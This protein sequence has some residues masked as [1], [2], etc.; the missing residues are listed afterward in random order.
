MDYRSLA[1]RKYHPLITITWLDRVAV[2]SDGAPGPGGH[3]STMP[4]RVKLE[5][6]VREVRAG[7][8]ATAVW[9]TERRMSSRRS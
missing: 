8:R 3:R 1:L 2:E 5:S 4:A 6:V 9:V 7:L